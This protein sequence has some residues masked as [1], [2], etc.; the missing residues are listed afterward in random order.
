MTHRK[1][2]MAGRLDLPSFEAPAMSLSWSEDEIVMSCGEAVPVRVLRRPGAARTAPLVL[3]LHGGTF[4]TGTLDAGRNVAGLL[5]HAGATVVSVDYPLASEKPFPYPLEIAYAAL[6]AVH[7]QRAKWSGKRALLLVAG[8]EAGGNLAAGVALMARDQKAPPLAGQI[9]ISP[10]LDPAL[11]TCS[12]RDA[13][14]G[15]VGCKWADGW[16]KYLGSADKA[17]HPYAAPASATRLAGLA[18]ALVVTAADDPMRDESVRYAEKLRQAQVGV[19]LEVFDAPTGWPASLS[20][21]E[22]RQAAW[23]D[24]LRILF[25]TFFAELRAAIRPGLPAPV[26]I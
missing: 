11:A 8:E 7:R 18:P 15:P 2:P 1:T 9:L 14:A 19:H 20:E 25:A 23:A 6:E 4:I 17:A 21:A 12:I 10:M 13:E 3:H 26:F 24:R 16:Q 22:A 5:A